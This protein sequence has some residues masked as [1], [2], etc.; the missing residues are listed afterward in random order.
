MYYVTTTRTLWGQLTSV[1]TPASI[2]RLNI[3]RAFFFLF[4]D[5]KEVLPFLPTT[6]LWCYWFRECKANPLGKAEELLLSNW[7][8]LTSSTRRLMLR[9]GFQPGTSWRAEY[10][11]VCVCGSGRVMVLEGRLSHFRQKSSFFICFM[12]L[13]EDVLLLKFS[14][15]WTRRHFPS[16]AGSFRAT[17]SAP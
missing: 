17:T 12:Y 14:N 10:V 13:A 15:H 3:N 9:C 16:W 4:L 8:A 1:M 5:E 11:C 6:P 2:Y 7:L